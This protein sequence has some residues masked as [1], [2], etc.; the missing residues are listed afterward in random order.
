MDTLLSPRRR[1]VIQALGACAFLAGCGEVPG[2][3]RRPLAVFQGPAM[4]TLWNAKLAGPLAEGLAAKASTA[5]AAALEGVVARMSTYLDTSE[6]SLFNRHPEATPLAVSRETLEVFALARE[7]S[8]ASG[9][10]FDVTVAPAVDAWGFGPSKAQRIPAAAELAAMASRIDWRAIAIDRGAG[11]LAKSRDGVRADLSGIA[12]GYGVDLAAR[13]LDALGVADYLVEAGGELRARGRNADAKPWRIGI[14]RPDA[15]PQQPLLVVPLD[16]LSMATS[17]DYRIY[18]EQGG[19]RYSH[20]IDPATREPVRG[21]LASVTVVARDC[22][23]A[24]AMATAL[25]VMGTARGLEFATGRGMA[26]CFI[27]RTGKGKFVD[28]QTPAFAR[29]GAEHVRA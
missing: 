12:K 25:F 13:G 4:G 26:A 22:A 24:D 18:F 10:A 21:S 9:G 28:R 27:E 19:R 6:L 23:W 11:T 14:E 8:E 15:V 2:I 7:V 29:L 5:V 20:E 3:T 16:G 1:T 17:G